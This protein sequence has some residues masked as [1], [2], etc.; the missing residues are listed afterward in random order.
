MRMRSALAITATVLGLL[1]LP[2]A[3]Q[4][5]PTTA[6]AKR[7]AD[8]AFVVKGIYISY[9]KGELFCLTDGR[10][11]LYAF[12][13]ATGCGPLIKGGTG[14]GLTKANKR[15]SCAQ[16]INFVRQDMRFATK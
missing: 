12:E 5:A 8:N 2:S 14:Y 10:P 1:T 7:C 15:I 11:E 4:A 9:G 16:P 3:A 6:E 13:G